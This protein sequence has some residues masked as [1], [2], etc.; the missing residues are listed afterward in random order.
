MKKLL[1]F[2]GLI[3]LANLTFSQ[4]KIDENFEDGVIP[5]GWI[6]HDFGHN[7]DTWIIDNYDPHGG[8]YHLAV[9]TYDSDST[10]LGIADDWIV[11][12]QFIVNDGDVLSFWAKSDD[13][14]YL[15]SVHVYISKSTT[16]V[17][18][19]TYVVGKIEAPGEYAKFSFDLTTIDG[20][21]DGDNIYIGFHTNTCGYYAYLDDIKVSQPTVID[22][23]FEDGI[24]VDWTVID[25]GTNPNTWTDTIEGGYE[26]TD[27][28]WVDT[29]ESGYGPADD[30]LIT[31]QFIIR[32]GDIISFWLY[33]NDAT[34]E[35][36]LF[37]ELSKTGIATG[38]FTVH[39]DTIY[40]V[41][42][43]TKYQYFVDNIDGI[44]A[45]D[46]VYLAIRAKSNGSRVFLDNVRIGEYVPPV[47]YDAYVVGDDKLAVLYDAPLSDG[48]YSAE[49]FSLS[50]SQDLTF[51]NAVVDANNENI[52]ILTASAAFTVDNTL[53]LLASTNSETEIELYAGILPVAYL[54][55]TNSV[56]IDG[57]YNA[58][59]KGIVS[60]N[61]E[62]D[63]V[64]IADAA[65]AHNGI[66]T[67]DLVAGDA[68]IN[69]G[70]EILLYGQKDAYRN[71]TELYPAKLI[72]VISTGNTVYDATVISGSDIATTVTADADPA[73]QYEGSLVKVENVSITSWDGAYFNCTD[74]DG[75]TTFLIGDAFELYADFG[76]TMLSVGANHNIT[77]IITGRDGTYL[78]TVR[79]P[80]DITT[81]TAIDDKIDY[82]F[83]I[84]PNPVSSILRIENMVGINK[85]SVFN[86]IGQEII[87]KNVNK[88]SNLDID[89]SGL[90]TGMY[91][92]SFYGENEIVKSSKIIKK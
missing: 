57:G 62:Y 92:I 75:A 60:A 87:V 18:S 69:V 20:V 74:D 78:L 23:D 55:L 17:A 25:D 64:W 81:A 56:T 85:V 3:I 66:N 79:G 12:S 35:D 32:A 4:A 9:D 52:V 5:A 71:Q 89:M 13:A 73:E 63:R 80:E 38:D 14:D 36:T 7:P 65:G 28:V 42:D 39:V 46:N 49:E 45:N 88:K 40:T 44:A 83:N 70:D 59:F 29:Y 91:F 43:W 10:D 77:G 34:Y 58:T 2:I 15:D 22:E 24:P 16:D 21:N 76:E 82:D 1:L 19:F 86:S 33:G 72:E 51:T 54:S 31:P 53:D 26:G 61:N 37:I 30:W 47:F 11:T 48:E 41:T 67:Y 8:T 90:R 6:T 68:E 84:Y 50:G 27:G